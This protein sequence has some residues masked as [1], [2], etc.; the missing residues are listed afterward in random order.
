M[1]KLNKVIS[2]PSMNLWLTGT[3][4][5][6]FKV[7]HVKLSYRCLRFVWTHLDLLFFVSVFCISDTIWLIFPSVSRRFSLNCDNSSSASLICAVSSLRVFW[8]SRRERDVLKYPPV[9]EP[10]EDTCNMTNHYI[11]PRNLHVM[12]GK[13]LSHMII[14]GSKCNLTLC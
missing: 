8:I 2:K 9:S 5:P 4:H 14:T 7:T 6:I 10:F 13:K 12:H 3:G 1:V 11:N